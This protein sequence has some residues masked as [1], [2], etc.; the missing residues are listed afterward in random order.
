MTSLTRDQQRAQRA[1]A[2]V[3]EVLSAVEKRILDAGSNDKRKKKAKKYGEEYLSNANSLP[4]SIVMNGLGQACAMLLAQAKNQAA[5]EDAHR[6]L[7]DHLHNWL[8]VGKQAV[9]PDQSNLVEAIIYHGQRQ[10]T[11]A[12]VEALAYLEWLKKFAQA[13]LAGEGE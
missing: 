7:Y 5:E 9:Y 10:Y 3:K 2:N 13:Y 6:L 8:C 12:Q 1:L 4:A 11:Q